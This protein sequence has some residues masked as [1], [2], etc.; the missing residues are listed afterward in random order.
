MRIIPLVCG[1]ALV[2]FTLSASAQQSASNGLEVQHAWARATAGPTGV[3]YLRILNK[4]A[5]PDSLMSVKTPVAEKAELH[6][7]KMENGVM[8]MRSIGPVAIAPGQAVVFKPGADHV[9]LVGLKH[10]L[11]QGESFPLTL[12]FE[13]AGNLQVMVRVERAG[14]MGVDATGPGAMPNMPGMD[15]GGMK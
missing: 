3:A 14:A 4:G 1:V 15:H 2:V 8:T 11:K 10:P 6:E 13:K 5:T 12:S 9:M 7:T